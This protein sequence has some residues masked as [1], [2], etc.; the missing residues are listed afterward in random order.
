MNRDLGT[1]QAGAGTDVAQARNGAQVF[2]DGSRGLQQGIRVVALQRELVFFTGAAQSDLEAGA[3]QL[4]QGGAH[5]ALHHLLA[6]ALA[7]LIQQHGE[8]GLAHLGTGTTGKRV[9]AHGAAT[10]CGVDAAHMRHF[11]NEGARLLGRRAGLCQRGS[12]RQ[13]QID[14]G[15]GVVVRRYEATGN[16]GHQKQGTDEKANGGEHGDPAVV[17]R[18]TRDAQVQRH[19]HRFLVHVGRWFH[20][21]SG[22]H[23]GQHAGHDQRGKYREYGSPAKLLEEF[24]HHTAH[25]GGWQKH[26]DQGKGGG[27]N[28]K[29]Y[30]VGR[31]H[32]CLVG[33]LAHAQVALDVFNLHDRII[34]QNA[35]DQGQGQ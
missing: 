29:S 9:C 33:R 25:E 18:P 28:R 12:W 22:H 4:G 35:D 7:A 15:L 27:D 31:F 13:F 14:L 1:C 24:T 3:W 19:P 26:G 6:R 32:G 34:H 11:A 10:G 5:F 23:R 17:K 30:F 16:Q 20:Q 21:V 8:R 2:L